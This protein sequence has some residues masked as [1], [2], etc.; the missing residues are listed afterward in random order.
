MIASL[1]RFFENCL[2]PVVQETP[3]HAEHRLQ[4]ASAALLLELAHAD[5]DFSAAEQ[6]ALEAIL[7]DCYALTDSELKELWQL[8][9]AEKSSATSL[10]QFTALFNEHYDYPAKL[11]L[12][13][14]LWRVAWADGRLDRYEE[15]TIRKVA[16]L[17]YMSH[18]D[19]IQTKQATRPAATTGS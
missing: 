18:K 8:A 5:H 1:T 6:Q 15:H 3:Q 7:R 19:F 10:Y 9:Q 4:L 11:Q 13:A 2:K 12:L 16:D 14:N 17:L